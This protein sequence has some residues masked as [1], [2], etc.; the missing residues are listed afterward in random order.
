MSILIAGYFNQKSRLAALLRTK[1]AIKEDLQA[2]IDRGSPKIAVVSKIN[3]WRTS[4]VDWC[5]ELLNFGQKMPQNS[6]VV[7]DR[8]NCTVHAST[9]EPLVRAIGVAKSH[10]DVLS[11]QD[12]LL[13]DSRR[14]LQPHSITN[15]ERDT[16]FPSSFEIEATSLRPERREPPQSP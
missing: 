13:A 11:W 3:D 9:G 10:Q 1:N 6:A 2:I 16:E 7:I 12:T 4:K 15:N 14:N 5:E 8:L